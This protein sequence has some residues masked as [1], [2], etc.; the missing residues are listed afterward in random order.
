[1]PRFPGI[2]DVELQ[3]DWDPGF[4]ID[5]SR[6]RDR[7]ELYWERHRGTPKAF[8][9]IETA[10]QMWANRFGNA[11]AIRFDAGVFGS[12]EQADN[13]IRSSL[14][15]RSFG[16]VFR[17]VRAEAID[18][19]ASGPARYFGYLFAGLSQFIIVAAVLLMAMVF[20]IGLE[21]RR[22]QI[23]LFRAVG[24]PS[25]VV[26]GLLMRETLIVSLIGCVLGVPLGAAYTAAIMVGLQ[27]VWADAI[28]GAPVVLHIQ[29]ASMAIGGGVAL[30]AAMGATWLVTRG[31]LKKQTARLLTH[32]PELGARANRPS[33]G[34]IGLIALLVLAALASMG[35]SLSGTA[36][37]QTLGFM[38][39][40]TLLLVA[41]LLC[42]R[43]LMHRRHRPSTDALT[44]RRLARLG[45]TRRSGRSLAA[46]SLLAI[47]VF[48]MVAVSANRLRTP[49]D[50]SDPSGGAGGY[51][52]M[53]ES[54]TPI[55]HGLIETEDRVID[56]TMRHAAVLP[57]RVH[58][59]TEASC[60]NLNRAPQPMLLGVEPET[61]R[62]RGAFSFAGSSNGA[63]NADAWL[64]L[65]KHDSDEPDVVPAIT[66]QPTAMWSLGMTIGD[67]LEYTD[68]RG[69]PFRV[70]LVGVV[71][72]SILQGR[73]LIDRDRFV[74]RFPSSSGYR[75]FLIDTDRGE[76][77]APHLRR[78]YE[79]QGMS[80]VD[81]RTRLRQLNAVQNTYLSI[82]L[83]LGGLGLVLGTLGLGV[84]VWRNV[85]DRRAEHAA[86]RAVGF[87]KRRIAR[88][89]MAEHLVLGGLGL[90]CGAGPA[91]VASVPTLLDRSA[92]VSVMP[93]LIALL[94]IASS[95][96]LW[97]TLATKLSM[98][99]PLNAALRDE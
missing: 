69:R 22:G 30:A 23:G 79:D 44:T 93:V 90:A 21:Q 2:A 51:A 52:L 37:A 47:G 3:A 98:R 35:W 75:A 76:D 54:T 27:T 91:L 88:L 58:G 6:I 74:E 43:L 71:K 57:M 41:A 72:S 99:G 95:G 80:V 73:F 5:T 89:V 7:D 14:D 87:Q 20:V 84:V 4:A 28:N 63:T 65:G 94:I 78:T 39:G 31:Y 50:L 19:A 96:A 66:D 24:M 46:I 42:A 18:A 81:T 62:D 48:M 17:P 49:S 29:P 32:T 8:V 83:M 77:I 34:R 64:Q 67:E 26:R 61:L 15:P 68:E 97:I 10:Q 38:L 85:L 11:T 12:V 70:R 16:L 60:L 92:G 59:D 9:S 55:Y 36:E 53:A 13:T 45:V 40:G 82:F 1:M 33:K 56:E 86:M 25:G